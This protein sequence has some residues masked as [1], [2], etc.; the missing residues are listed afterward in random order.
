[1]DFNIEFHIVYL[2]KQRPNIKLEYY[3]TQQS[4]YYYA[5]GYLQYMCTVLTG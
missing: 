1:M 5:H 4:E 3:K 2:I